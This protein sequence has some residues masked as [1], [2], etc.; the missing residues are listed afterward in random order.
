MEKNGYDIYFSVL[1]AE[2]WM[3]TRG[4]LHTVQNMYRSFR[5]SFGKNVE[6]IR[7]RGVLYC[8]Q[9]RTK[10]ESHPLFR[11][12]C[13]PSTEFFYTWSG[14]TD[15]RDRI[16]IFR[17]KSSINWYSLFN[18]NIS[19]EWL[20]KRCTWKVAGSES[21]L[22]KVDI[23]NGRFFLAIKDEGIIKGVWKVRIIFQSQ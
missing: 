19:Y 14:L 18:T 3:W 1:N 11:T 12:A 15:V 4:N 7:C 6:I 8:I 20:V 17:R 5:E 9:C 2:R 23:L 21:V 13:R 22:E 16:W 10:W